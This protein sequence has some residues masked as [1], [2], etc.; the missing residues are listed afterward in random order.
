MDKGVFA[1]AVLF[2]EAVAFTAVVPFHYVCR[3]DGPEVYFG[4]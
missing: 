2:D 4:M 1:A 3:H